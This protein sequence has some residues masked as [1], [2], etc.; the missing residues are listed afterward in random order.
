M[1]ELKVGEFKMWEKIIDAAVVIITE[2][3]KELI[4]KQ[5]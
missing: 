1:G 2:I 5:G 3:A 4:K